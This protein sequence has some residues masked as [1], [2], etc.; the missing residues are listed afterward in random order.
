MKQ[1]LSSLS[2]ARKVSNGVKFIRVLN[3]LW[4]KL[5][6]QL[7]WDTEITK[8]IYMTALNI[9][10]HSSAA[11]R[12]SKK[13]LSCNIAYL[14]DK[15]MYTVYCTLWIPLICE[16]NFGPVSLSLIPIRAFAF[17]ITMSYCSNFLLLLS[18]ECLTKSRNVTSF[19]NLKRKKKFISRVKNYDFF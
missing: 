9:S 11:T 15:Y 6:H 7:D 5:S 16:C 19:Q 18:L 10:L 2:D 4:R 3:I 8:K 12:D 13:D 1:N 17:R 14:L